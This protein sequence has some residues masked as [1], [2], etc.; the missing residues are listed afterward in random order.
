NRM[1][2]RAAAG[3][4]IFDREGCSGCH[5]PPYYTSGKLT[6]ADG[7][8]PSKELLR[9]YDVLPISVKTD[10]SL[11]M[12]TRKGTGFYKI[13]S[14]R[15]VWY[16]GRYLHDGAVTTLEEMFNPDRL[17]PD[18]VPSGFKGLDK[19]RAVRGHEFGLR[20]SA[21]DRESLIAFLK[22]L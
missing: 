6:L 16:R 9:E 10:P 1:D 13:P 17:K 14:L 4:K 8:T 11:A 21:P 3:K 12:K 18:F 20:I 5:T 22:T 2:D 15:G 7:F 19:T